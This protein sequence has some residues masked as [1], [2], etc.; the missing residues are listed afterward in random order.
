MANSTAVTAAPRLFGGARPRAC[1]SSPQPS[2]SV[3]VRP[4]WIGAATTSR[5]G[6]LSSTPLPCRSVVRHP[7]ATL[8]RSPAGG[9][10][11]RRGEC[12]APSPLTLPRHWLAA[13][14]A[15]GTT[16]TALPRAADGHLV[17]SA[18]SLD[19]VPANSHAPRWWGPHWRQTAKVLAQLSAT[20]LTVMG[21]EGETVP[22]GPALVGTPRGGEYRR[23]AHRLTGGRWGERAGKKV[24]EGNCLL[25]LHERGSRHQEASPP[26]AGEALP[27]APGAQKSLQCH[28]HGAHHRTS[29]AATATTPRPATS[30]RP[31]AAPPGGAVGKWPA[32]SSRRPPP[33]R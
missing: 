30:A 19:R 28:K 24:T 5:V 12:H 26:D 33:R 20:V 22:A 13:R 9:P 29:S 14:S 11:C 17:G 15:R 3:L 16:V 23:G 27:S 21:V 25:F 1:V 8:G 7:P 10:R 31:A 18:C 32:R 6:F 2:G 4:A